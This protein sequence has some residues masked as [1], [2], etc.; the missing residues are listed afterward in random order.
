MFPR[1][2][3]PWIERPV[4][5]LAIDV[6]A[7]EP[8]DGSAGDYV[9]SEVPAFGEARRHHRRSHAV[10]GYRDDA[11]MRVLVRDHGSHC[12]DLGRM[13]GREAASR[14]PWAG[15]LPEPA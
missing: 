6:I 5:A 11:G 9:G 15:T 10:G 12:P 1:L 7:D 8:T 4:M 13:A 14:R 3:G 2:R